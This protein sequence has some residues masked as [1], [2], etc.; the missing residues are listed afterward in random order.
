M[1]L[2]VSDR[3]IVYVGDS[4]AIWVVEWSCQVVDVLTSIALVDH[5]LYQYLRTGKSLFN[6]THDHRSCIILTMSL[7]LL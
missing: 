2:T 5:P 7:V 6:L 4:E 3:D 1:R